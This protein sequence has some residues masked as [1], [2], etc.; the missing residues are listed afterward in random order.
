MANKTFSFFYKIFD[1]SVGSLSIRHTLPLIIVTPLLASVAVIGWFNFQLGKQEIEKLMLQ[2]SEKS[3]Q[4]IE[5]N[6]RN[7]LGKPQVLLPA[8][9][10]AI[11]S[12]NVDINNLPEVKRYFWQQI[13]NK[14][15]LNSIYIGTEKGNYVS[16]EKTE[17][18]F[19]EKFRDE[20]TNS[21]RN[22]YEVDSKGNRTRLIKSMEYDP[23]VRLWY[24]FAKSV[25]KPT[26]TPVYQFGSINTVG[27]D[28]SIPIYN[29]E[30]GNFAGVISTDISLVQISK[31]LRNLEISQNGKALIMERTGD[32]I[33]ISTLEQ[34]F[35]VV[36]NQ[37]KRLNVRESQDPTIQGTGQ[38]LIEK[39][40]SLDQ[41]ED[42]QQFTFRLKGN[43]QL[44]QVT[45]LQNQEGIDWLMVVVIPHSDFLKHIY[46][47]TTLTVIIGVSVAGI[48]VI[49]ALLLVRW[50]IKPIEQLQ[51]A[52]ETIESQNFDQSILE[53]VSR[54]RDEFGQLGKVMSAMANV[55]YSREQNW[56]QMID[57]LQ[58][59]DL[60]K[61]KTK[62]GNNSQKQVKNL[63]VL[64]RESQQLRTKIGEKDKN[65][66]N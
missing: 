22:F 59:Q 46:T 42:K 7:Y 48:A 35:K 10:A 14:T 45:P 27:M 51:Q 3:T 1:K 37:T 63:E 32:V 5:L 40:K 41:I 57:Q 8:Y 44:V 19:M 62:S 39:F 30:S 23:R 29:Q 21:N 20:S 6:L 47:Y 34:P 33:A 56:K 12:G 9:L 49:L 58:N 16:Y 18:E 65:S 26:W 15:S 54:R 55:I 52:A 53:E 11:Q 66:R 36:N 13:Q 24:K 17:N 60:Q 2:V 50:I 28:F 38:Y 25:G 61:Q 31:F 64:L 4:M 43:L